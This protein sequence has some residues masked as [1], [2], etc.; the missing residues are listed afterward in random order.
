MRIRL[1]VL[2][3]ILLGTAASLV[4]AQPD[5]SELVSS[6][7]DEVVFRVV[8]PSLEFL[9]STEP[10]DVAVSIP[11]WGSTSSE[12]GP[13]L[14]ARSVYIGIPDGAE[15]SIE[16]VSVRTHFEPG[17]IPQPVPVREIV[18]GENDLPTQSV[19]Y[20]RNRELF[21]RPF[22]LQW[23]ELERTAHL[24]HLP[25]A[26]VGIRPVRWDPVRQGLLVADEIEV[27]VRFP[28]SADVRERETSSRAPR[29]PEVWDRRYERAVLNWDQARNFVRLAPRAPVLS[30]ASLVGT[31]PE[32]R[33]D[34]T[35]TDLYRVPF[36]TLTAAGWDLG[37]VP[38]ERLVMEERFWDETVATERVEP[39][40]IWVRD[41]DSDGQ[42]GPGDAVV[43]YGMMMF[44]RLDPEPWDKRYGRKNAYWLTVRDEGGARMPTSAS[45]LGRTDLVSVG[46]YRWT[47]H[48]EQDVFYMRITCYGE[49]ASPL[50]A[51]VENLVDD[52][53]YWFGGDR[54]QSVNFDLPGYVSAE[55]LSV[56]VRDV[57]IQSAHN[58][59]RFDLLL[60][61]T[62]TVAITLPGLTIPREKDAVVFEF[63]Q[64]DLAGIQLAERGDD[65][66]IDQPNP[67]SGGRID[68]FR[69]TYQRAP[70][71]FDDQIDFDTDAL[72]GPQ[73]WDLTQL[74]GTDVVLVDVTT[75]TA[76]RRLTVAPSQISGSG[77]NRT[78][79]VQIDLGPTG[80][81]RTYAVRRA[82]TL[83][84]PAAVE[85]ASDVDLGLPRSS[86]VVVIAHP[87]F[88]AGMQRWVDHRT[89]QGWDV[90]LLS[91]R[92]VFDQFDGGRDWPTAIRNFLRY[93]FRT[94][95]TPPSFV[96]LVGDA[97]S[98]HA[99][100]ISGSGPDYVPTQTVFSNAFSDQGSE[101]VAT[102]HYFVDDLI[103]TG[104]TFDFLADAHIGRL[105]AGSAPGDAGQLEAMVDKIIAYD[106][107]LSDDDTWRNRGLFVADDEFSSQVDYDSDYRFRGDL[108]RAWPRTGESVFRYACREA[109]RRIR[110][111]DFLD[112]G[113]DSLY[114]A[115]YLDSVACLSR[116]IPVEDPLPPDCVD[117]S[118]NVNA[119][120]EIVD[121]NR[122]AVPGSYFATRDYSNNVAKVPRTLRRK[123]KDGNLFVV[124]Q[125]HANRAQAGHEEFWLDSDLQGRHDSDD[126]ENFGKPFL[127]FGFGCHM[128]D[129]SHPLE[130]GLGY[131]DSMVERMLFLEGGR[132][133]VAGLA[134]S[135]YEWLNDNHYPL[136]P[137]MEN[138][139]SDPP[140]GPDGRSRWLLGEMID[141]GKA[142]MLRIGSYLADYLG[143]VPTYVLL[144]DPTMTI[145]LAPPRADLVAVDGEPW[146]AG[147]PLRAPVGNDQVTIEVRFRDEVALQNLAVLAGGAVLDSTEFQILPDPDRPESDRRALVRYAPTLDVPAEDYDIVVRADDLA[148]RRKE[149]VLPVRLETEFELLRDGVFERLDPADVVDLGDSVRVSFSA[150]VPVAAEDLSFLS[151]GVP[152]DLIEVT[153]ELQGAEEDWSWTLLV[154]ITAQAPGSFDLALEIQRRDG[155]IASRTI[156][157]HPASENV[158]LVYLANMPNPFADE[159]H[160]VYRLDGPVESADLSVFTLSGRKI[161]EAKGPV[162]PMENYIL[163]DG[164][165]R[166]GDP[167]ANGVYFYRLVIRT[168][169]GG[170]ISRIERIARVR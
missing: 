138:W 8:V 113:V 28:R 87:D 45:T 134:S 24:R 50:S 124:F 40:P 97:S 89:S 4:Q 106:E 52:H 7:Q 120:G 51:S 62:E 73:Q 98:D 128:A 86:D 146:V 85:R 65:F 75:P 140:T 46:S 100:V 99:Q 143:M 108:R 16:V 131:G 82:G 56:R 151:A 102:D 53:Y 166:E 119:G 36:E 30:R 31:G 125:A 43:F 163:W 133:A 127:F 64:S 48:F 35:A 21:S 152:L 144:G 149:I 80:D 164:R 132:G 1:T 158:S 103:G 72:T 117:W 126:L 58:Q 33:I 94:R 23:A 70:R 71:S 104:N 29:D 130:A 9:P 37:N 159:T 96:L 27:R 110:G 38:A 168:L 91:V 121:I 49:T 2:V 3:P 160:F 60:G 6:A 122:V 111:A 11:G 136:I 129:F 109:E 114:M 63:D 14:P 83:A 66:I 165:D 154:E 101:L 170:E 162:L 68:Y 69:W 42:F 145:D 19:Q 13:E 123:M 15:P 150:P 137:F 169:Q 76:P 61:E 88:L 20:L 32:F 153:P 95:E 22:P 157:V 54:R 90:E 47:K 116:C 92:D 161:W 34:V 155:S 41:A 44:D 167:V 59:P 79:R 107:S 57:Y 74:G 139:F 5:P 77:S 115:T 84:L 78:V 148:G 156:S 142:H 12:G 81:E 118:C 39:V 67:T 105:P 112:F 17:R 18:G 147:E 25:I 10:G 55:G 93:T 135:G 141:G 26:I